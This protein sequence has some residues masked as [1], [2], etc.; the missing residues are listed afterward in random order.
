MSAK[1][2]DISGKLLDENLK[3]D[4]SIIMHDVHEAEKQLEKWEKLNNTLYGFLYEAMKQ[5][6]IEYHSDGELEVVIDNTDIEV[7]E[8]KKCD[9]H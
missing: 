4:L 5:C 8:V 9:L 1:I 3:R 7:R 6:A 2:I